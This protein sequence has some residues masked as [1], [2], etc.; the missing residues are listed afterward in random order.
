VVVAADMAAVQVVVAA[1]VAATAPAAVAGLVVATAAERQKT[2]ASSWRDV[3][4]S[5][6]S[7]LF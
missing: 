6:I 7:W 5:Y 3:K 4:A 2:S 1:A